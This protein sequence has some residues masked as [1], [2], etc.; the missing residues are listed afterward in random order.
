M[1]RIPFLTPRLPDPSVV[2]QDY[3]EIFES[4]VFTNS[5]PFE[6]R[7]ASEL[8]RWIG[9]D[10]G[11][12]VTA[13]ASVGIQLACRTLFH[14]DRRLVPVASFTA[15]A[16]PL[17][18]MWS[19]FEPVLLD[20]EPETWQPDLRMAERFLRTEAGKVAGILLTNTFGTA[21]AAIDAWETLAAEHGVPL[22]IDSAAGF[23]SEYSWGE[24]LGSRGDCEIFSFHATK[25]MAIGEGGAVVSRSH[26]F[27]REMNQLK[28]FGFD[29]DRTSRGVGQNGKLPELAS[30]MGIRQ[31]EVFKDRLTKRHEVLRRYI[32]QLEPLGCEFQT[33]GELGVP[34][35]V[36]AALP[37][38]QLREELGRKLDEVEV[39]WRSY[40]NPPIHGHP[41]FA[42]LKRAGDLVVTE[43][44]CG[45]II[46]LPLDDGLSSDDV[47]RVAGA[48]RSVV[49]R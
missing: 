4:G 27:I 7:F 19:G 43:E 16:A 3:R 47:A 20:I 45:R 12:A 8:A 24:P 18:L 15:P 13:N 31:L 25:T 36:S 39:G 49:G 11:V 14:R 29:D 46:S 21:N 38:R 26:G 30:A 40:F 6:G 23:A 2:A 28:N 1:R 35:F 41:T 33:D 37:S 32:A 17:A 48:V 42:E 5:G 34:A 22:V 44:L 10:V 9:R